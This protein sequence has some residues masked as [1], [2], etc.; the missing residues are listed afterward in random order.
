L[1]AL[2]PAPPTPMTLMRTGDRQSSWNENIRAPP[3]AQGRAARRL[4]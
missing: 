4:S 3:L 1:I 2:H